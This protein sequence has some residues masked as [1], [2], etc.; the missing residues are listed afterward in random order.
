LFKF[1]FATVTQSQANVSQ[2][3]HC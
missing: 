1:I 2:H 3:I